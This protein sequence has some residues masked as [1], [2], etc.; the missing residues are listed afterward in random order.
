[1]FDPFFIPPQWRRGLVA[2][3]VIVC[4]ATTLTVVHSCVMTETIKMQVPVEVREAARAVHG[5]VVASV[6][7]NMPRRD[8]VV[9]HDTVVTTRVAVRRPSVAA[10][11]LQTVALGSV[12]VPALL[13][14]R[15]FN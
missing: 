4:S 10:S 6:R 13:L 11:L 14:R 1:M 9:V 7:V 2:A 5:T 3:L 15:N 12:P 8:T